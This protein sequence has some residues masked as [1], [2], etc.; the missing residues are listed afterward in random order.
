[1]TNNSVSRNDFLYNENGLF[2]KPGHIIW[3][4]DKNCFTAIVG[5]GMVVTVFD[6]TQGL[7]GICHYLF[8]NQNS[9]ASSVSALSPLAIESLFSRF[10]DRGSTPNSLQV[11]MI[12]GA[13]MPG[14]LALIE[15]SDKNIRKGYEILEK[16]NIQPTGFHVGGYYGRGVLM[17]TQSGKVRISKLEKLRSNDWVIMNAPVDKAA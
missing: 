9:R 1:M 13:C 7:A 5:F 4:G 3:T 2:I 15:L 8:P 14:N 12:G 6:E 16:Y 10:F 11:Q 17:N